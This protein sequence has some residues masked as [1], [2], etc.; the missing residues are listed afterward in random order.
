MTAR[1][2]VLSVYPNAVIQRV[3]GRGWRILLPSDGPYAE[4]GRGETLHKAW[5]DAARWKLEVTP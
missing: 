3:T 2:K 1:E 4:L 5:D